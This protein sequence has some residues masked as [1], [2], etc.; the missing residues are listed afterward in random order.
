MKF[1]LFIK[2]FLITAAV[3]IQTISG[4]AQVTVSTST[5]SQ[6]QINDGKNYKWKSS[7]MGQEFS[8]E[9]RGKIE[10]T[11]DDKDIKTITSDG[12]LEIS[13]PTFG[14]KRTIIIEAIGNKVKKEYYEGRTLV[15]W[16][17]KG[18]AWLG[19]ILPEIVRSTGIS[20]ESRVNR[21]YK[22]GGTTAVLEEIK[23]IDSDYV[24]TI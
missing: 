23:R 17:E 18:R 10:V 11:D 3:C 1:R 22:Q 6:V 20:A 7:S 2:A 16:D 9:L 14:S 12:Y 5:N 4:S 19:E 13:K 8:I 15:S 21:Y 24:V